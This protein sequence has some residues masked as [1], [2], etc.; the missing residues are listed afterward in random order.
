METIMKIKPFDLLKKTFAAWSQDHA[1]RLA[2]ALA[3][4]SV[5]SIAPLLLIATAVAGL[6]FGRE[7]AQGQISHEMESLVGRQGAE[8]VQTMIAS[9][10]KPGGGA[11]AGGIGLIMLIA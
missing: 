3:Y 11:L 4:Y 7:A 8:A 5:F 10:H 9:A 1:A 6:V 2:A